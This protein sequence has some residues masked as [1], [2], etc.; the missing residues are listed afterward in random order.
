MQLSLFII[1]ILLY[2]MA[3]SQQRMGVEGLFYTGGP[4][5]SA[6]VPRAYFEDSKG[7]YGELRYNY[8]GPQTLSLYGGKTF[9]GQHDVSFSFTP[10]AGL[11]VG[12]LKGGSA[13]MNM[14]LEYKRLSITSLWQYTF[15]SG[16]PKLNF[17]YSWSEL[18]FRITEKVYA[19]LALQQTRLYGAAGNWDP[20]VEMSFLIQKWTFPLYLFNPISNQRHFVIGVTR[21]WKAKEPHILNK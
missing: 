1:M 6:A 4:S 3:D 11:L 2:H 7:W 19:G 8:E 17:F 21:E 9:A 16:G 18:G 20:G 15:L 13:G 14:G 12:R 10:M 5:R